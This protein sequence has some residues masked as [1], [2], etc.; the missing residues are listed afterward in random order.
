[1]LILCFAGVILLGFAIPE[2]LVI[3]VYGATQYDWNHNTFWYSPWGA[4]GVHKGIDIFGSAGT[5]VIASTSGVVIFRGEFTISGKM[6]VILGPKWR[7]HY[8]SHLQDYNVSWGDVVCRS[9]NIGAVGTSGNAKGKPPHL[10]YTI[11]SLIP[12]LWRW[13]VAP[14]GWKKIFFLNPSS[15]LI[16]KPPA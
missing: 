9:E 3:P 2:R 16:A 12:Y 13:D 1:M 11:F 14:Q 15:E 5:P 10:H 7:I 8:Y 6:L 4:S